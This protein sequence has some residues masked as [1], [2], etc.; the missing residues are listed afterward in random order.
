ARL[1][2]VL[3]YSADDVAT[4][5]AAGVSTGHLPNAFDSLLEWQPK[6]IPAVSFVG[7]RYRERE[8][9]L[10]QL[11]ERGV[12]VNAWGREWARSPWDIAR[13]G[14]W[15]SA[16]IP[17]DTDTPRAMYYGVM[18]GSTA[19]LKIHG[20]EH[21]GLS[22]RTFEAPGVGA[23][24]LIDRDAVAAHYEVGVETLVFH[25][26]DE[27]VDLIGRAGR[28]PEWS[29]DV[30]SAGMRRTAAEHTFVHRMQTVLDGWR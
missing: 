6:E 4:L 2:R 22:M 16:G 11:A 29:E 25:G 14:Q 30:R 18:A 7:A 23:L 12:P 24:S 9:L 3:S 1:D 20:R 17:V 19:T 5:E 27:L 8:Q 10:R 28:E 26:V 13:T 15:R 21:P